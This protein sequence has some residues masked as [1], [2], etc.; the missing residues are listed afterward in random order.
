MII[1]TGA[2]G[3]IGSQ[4]CKHLNRLG[5]QDLVAVDMVSPAERP[6]PLKDVRYLKYL[7]RK[8]LSGFLSTSQAKSQVQWILHIGANSHTTETNWELLQELNVGDS[9]LCFDW[10][11][12]NSKSLIYASSA[13]TYGG[14]EQGFDDQT[15]PVKLK[16]LNLY[17]KS[18]L[19]FDK[20]AIHQTQTPLSWYGLKFFN[21][22]GSQETHKGSQ[23][24]VVMHAFN[25]IKSTGGLKLFKSYRSEYKDG[26]QKRDFIYV[27]DICLW[28]EEL[29]NKKPKSGIYNMGTGRARSWLDLGRAVFKAMNVPEKIEFVEMPANLKNQY[30]YFTEAK[31]QKWLA[32]DLTAPKFSLEKGV[33]DYVRGFLEIQDSEV[34]DK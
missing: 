14:G 1:V 10:C 8:E 25:Q 18:K 16:A 4:I 29:M 11:A 33:E 23:A 30:Q 32:Q 2:N 15:D 21:V 24:S 17:G 26:E 7:D 22:Y 5:H 27:Q 6:A 12:Q 28:T 13:A 3:F 31:M 34:K 9:K 19:E 20:W